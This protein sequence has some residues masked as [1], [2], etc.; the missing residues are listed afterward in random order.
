MRTNKLEYEECYIDKKK[1]IS[2]RPHPQIES[3]DMKQKSFDYYMSTA[4]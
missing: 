3:I 4:F 1:K 2:I